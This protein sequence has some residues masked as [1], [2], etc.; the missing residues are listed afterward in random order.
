MCVEEELV[1]AE[2]AVIDRSGFRGVG[3]ALDLQ[4]SAGACKF[5]SCAGVDSAAIDEDRAA[6][7]RENREFQ[8]LPV[9]WPTRA[10]QMINDLEPPVLRRTVSARRCPSLRWVWGAI[11]PSGRRLRRQ[12]RRSPAPAHA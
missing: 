9:P 6:G 12:P 1:A 7:V 3:E 11:T 5:G 10:A 8:L 2:S 4:R